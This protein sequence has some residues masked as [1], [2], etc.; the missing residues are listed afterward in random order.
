[1]YG[2]QQATAEKFLT[3][4]YRYIE[5]ICQ[6]VLLCQ[7]FVLKLC[8]PIIFCHV[9]VHFDK[10]PNNHCQL[11]S[12]TKGQLCHIPC[13]EFLCEIDISTGDL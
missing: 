6:F 7:R 13:K 9:K 3:S 10:N 2:A 5:A 4:V 11:Y 1:M 12:L 8:P